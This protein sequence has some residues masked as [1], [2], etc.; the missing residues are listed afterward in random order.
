MPERSYWSG[1][2]DLTPRPRSEAEAETSYCT[3]EVRAV[4]RRS[5]PMPEVREG[6]QE[7]QPYVQGAVDARAKEGGEELLL[8]S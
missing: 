5:Y 3:P 8:T 6:G 7:E 4:A 2:E 1:R